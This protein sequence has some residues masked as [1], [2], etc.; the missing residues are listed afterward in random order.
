MITESKQ[1]WIELLL[2]HHW[3][4]MILS[5][6]LYFWRDKEEV[7]VVVIGGVTATRVIKVNTNTYTYIHIQ[8]LQVFKKHYDVRFAIC[9]VRCDEEFAV[10]NLDSNIIQRTNTQQ[11]NEANY[12]EHYS[13]LLHKNMY[14]RY[15]ISA[16]MLQHFRF[17]WNAPLKWSLEL[18]SLF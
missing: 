6:C 5:H 16:V 3:M 15:V 7:V 13:F 12:N 4:N 1:R 14:A 2:P 10:F 18:W 17:N 9:N 11:M 8:T